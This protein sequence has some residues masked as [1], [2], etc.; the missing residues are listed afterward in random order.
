MKIRTGFVSNSSSSSFVLLVEKTL[1]EEALA[2]LNEDLAGQ[3]KKMLTEDTVFGKDVV[4][5]QDLN[6]SDCSWLFEDME[7]VP[8]PYCGEAE[9]FCKH[10]CGDNELSGQE[11][12]DVYSDIVKA[13]D[14]EKAKHKC[15]SI[16]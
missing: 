15:W 4:V 9:E 8:C 10:C 14:E 6:A 12:F 13:R 7:S 2:E 5:I 11:V 16:G 3:V 1:H